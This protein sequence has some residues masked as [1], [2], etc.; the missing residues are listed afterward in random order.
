MGQSTETGSAHFL[1][2]RVS[3]WEGQGSIG[4]KATINKRGHFIHFSA[5]KKETI[6]KKL[7]VLNSCISI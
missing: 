7:A 2:L 3:F 5:D 4:A 1:L 6:Y